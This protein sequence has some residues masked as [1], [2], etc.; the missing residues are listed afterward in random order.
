MS[1]VRSGKDVSVKWFYT[2]QNMNTT[3]N[4][5]LFCSTELNS[6]VILSPF[7]CPCSCDRFAEQLDRI[8]E[9]MDKINADM[10]EAEKNLTGMEKCCGICVCPCQKWVYNSY[11]YIFISRCRWNGRQIIIV[12]IIIITKIPTSRKFL[13]TRNKPKRCLLLVARQR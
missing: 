3:Q 6:I 11:I 7:F 12:I 4:E 2:E 13:S 5:I 10:K 8:E 1:T 9:D